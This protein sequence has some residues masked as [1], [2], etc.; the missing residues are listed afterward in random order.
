MGSEFPEMLGS[1]T[2]ECSGL[3]LL[4]KDDLP[5]A[6]R[7]ASKGRIGWGVADEQQGLKFRWFFAEISVNISFSVVTEKWFTVVFRC[8]PFRIS[9]FQ[10]KL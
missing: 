4:G 3:L 8:F 10:K 6:G 1:S 5:V 2:L 7:R 9:K